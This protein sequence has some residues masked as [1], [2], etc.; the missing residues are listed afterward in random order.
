MK[1]KFEKINIKMEI[2]TWASTS[3]P[4]FTQ[5]EELQIFA[6]NLPQKYE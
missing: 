5:F 2:K 6:P 3:V 1:R 4:N